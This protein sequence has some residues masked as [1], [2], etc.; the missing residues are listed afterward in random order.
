MRRTIGACASSTTATVKRRPEPSLSR[1]SCVAVASAA[2]DPAVA[3]ARAQCFARARADRLEL[4]LVAGA[5]DER[6]RLIDRVRELNFLTG[7]VVEEP[8]AAI[9]HEVADD[10]RHFDRVATEARLIAADD[11][12]AALRLGDQLRADLVGVRKS[13]PARPSST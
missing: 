1:S 4:H 10:E 11:D 5:L 2:G 8:A 6:G 3:H 9:A 7:R 13:S 12:V